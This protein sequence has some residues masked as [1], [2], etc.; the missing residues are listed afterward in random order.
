M[1]TLSRYLPRKASRS[2]FVQSQQWKYQNDMGNLFKVKNKNTRTKSMTLALLTLNKQMPT[3]KVLRG[4]RPIQSQPKD[5]R[6]THKIR[7][8]FV[9][10]EEGFSYRATAFTNFSQ[11]FL[12]N[13]IDIMPFIISI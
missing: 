9:D 3:G 13:V 5:I 1:L 7:E 12:E 8:F 2:L 10:C 11:M 6:R 4:E